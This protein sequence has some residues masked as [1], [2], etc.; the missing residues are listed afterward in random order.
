MPVCLPSCPS[1]GVY[2]SHHARIRTTGTTS[3]HV[4]MM[5][6]TSVRHPEEKKDPADKTCPLPP[7]N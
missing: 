6:D 4:D 5:N 1:T 2:A 3:T 7:E